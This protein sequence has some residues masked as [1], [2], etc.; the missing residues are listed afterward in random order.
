[1]FWGFLRHL[2]GDFVDSGLGTRAICVSVHWTDLE[3][4]TTSSYSWNGGDAKSD[5]PAKQHAIAQNSNQCIK[6]AY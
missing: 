2:Y 5:S 4:T 3:N 1:M 6:L